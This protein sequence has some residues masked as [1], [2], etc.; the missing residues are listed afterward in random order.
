MTGGAAGSVSEPVD[1]KPSV[2]Q[3]LSLRRMP[4][5]SVKG[6]SS[7]VRR[8]GK[9]GKSGNEDSSRGFGWLSK[10]FSGSSVDSNVIFRYLNGRAPLELRRRLRKG[11]PFRDDEDRFGCVSKFSESC[12]R[13]SFRGAHPFSWNDAAAIQ[14]NTRSRRIALF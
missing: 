10:K 3:R 14:D 7:G 2:I 9:L 6:G 5:N 13:R 11:R 1:W 12:R 4:F 8:G